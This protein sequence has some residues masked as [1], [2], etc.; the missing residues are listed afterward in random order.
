LGQAYSQVGS[1]STRLRSTESK[2]E[3][4]AGTNEQGKIPSGQ[5]LA[6]P[7]EGP[8]SKQNSVKNGGVN[9]SRIMGG[10]ISLFGKD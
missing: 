2:S 5:R 8:P 4:Q 3:I 10:G 6:T 7:K 9:A 1:K